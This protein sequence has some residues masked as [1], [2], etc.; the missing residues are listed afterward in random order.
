VEETPMDNELRNYL[1]RRTLQIPVV[2]FLVSVVVF[3]VIHI[4]RGGPI[5]LIA[6]RATDTMINQMRDQYHLNEPLYVQYWMWLE[7]VLSGSLGQSITRPQPVVELLVSRLPVTLF[8]AFT[9]SLLAVA[10][11]LPAGYISAVDQY[12]WKDNA[13]TVVAFIGLS[14]P[15]FFLAILLIKL[16]SVEL[17]WLPIFTRNPWGSPLVQAFAMPTVALGTAMAAQTTRIL[18]SSMLDI[19]SENYVQVAR[20]K[21]LPTKVV[22]RS[23]VFKNALIPVITVVALQMGY[24]LGATVIVEEVFALPG[25]G[26]LA[27]DAVLERDFPVIQAVVM[28]YAVAYLLLNFTA[29]VLYGFIDPRIRYG[30]GS[31]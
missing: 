13:A 16:F 1:V 11:A 7:G 31:E 4:P 14:I 20:A 26:K 19:Y 27:L 17:G 9:S 28:F 25:L 8:L 12:S 30:G 15:N 29:D 6:G 10:I 24:A 2:L 21:G 3:G 18:R 22:N 5:E 23:I